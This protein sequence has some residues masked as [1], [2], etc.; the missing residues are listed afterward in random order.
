MRPLGPTPLV[1]LAALAAGCHHTVPAVVMP[2]IDTPHARVSND[3][4]ER[5]HAACESRG[6]KVLSQD[7]VDV[8]ARELGATF[9]EIIYEP[10]PAHLATVL[11]RCP[12]TFTLPGAGP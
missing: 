4:S 1:L 3:E 7:V 12:A 5:L 11:F 10:D 2:T 9:V 8:T 6:A